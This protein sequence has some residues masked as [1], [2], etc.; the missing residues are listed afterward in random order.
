[1]MPD[2]SDKCQHEDMGDS[3]FGGAGA[4][5]VAWVRMRVIAWPVSA[6]AQPG[7]A[8]RVVVTY[9]RRCGREGA[10]VPGVPS[11]PGTGS[12]SVTRSYVRNSLSLAEKRRWPG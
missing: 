1:M 6:P 8:F 2:K 5:G 12:W 10:V 7:G 4:A 11:D 3:L 9:L